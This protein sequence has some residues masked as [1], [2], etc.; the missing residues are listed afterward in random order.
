MGFEYIL[1]LELIG[2]VEKCNMRYEIKIFIKDNLMFLIQF[3]QVGKMSSFFLYKDG[4]EQIKVFGRRL[5][6]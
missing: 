3:N 2:F 6:V 1:N 4:Y 5:G